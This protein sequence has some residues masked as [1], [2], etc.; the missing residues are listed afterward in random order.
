LSYII[1]GA[2]FSVHNALGHY[3]REK[4]YSDELEKILEQKS[5]EY[6][7]EIRIGDSGNILDF[8]IEKKIIVELKAKDI[9]TKEDYYQL[10]RYLQS[11]GYKLGILVNFRSK[12]LHPKRVIRLDSQKISP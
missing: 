10:Q 12:Y 7:R 11:T 5:I 6:S 1:V 4:Q 8:L 3:S 2:C 9:V